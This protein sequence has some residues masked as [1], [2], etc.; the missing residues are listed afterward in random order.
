MKLC[1]SWRNK[2]GFCHQLFPNFA[3]FPRK[4]KTEKKRVLSALWDL[5]RLCPTPPPPPPKYVKH[6]ADTEHVP[7]ISKHCVKIWHVRRGGGGAINMHPLRWGTNGKNPKN[8]CH[9][10][11]YFSHCFWL[12]LV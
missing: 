4:Y 7:F 3:Y 9:E 10:I 2:Y 5:F 1:S 12:I 6:P 11:L 8:F